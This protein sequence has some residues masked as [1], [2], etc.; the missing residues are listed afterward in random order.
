[1][2]GINIYNCH[3]E[4]KKDEHCLNGDGLYYY[5]INCHTNPLTN[6]LTNW[7]PLPLS[8][9]LQSELSSLYSS[10]H[11]DYKEVPDI[12]TGYYYILDRHREAQ[13]IHD[14]ISFYDRYSV[15]YTLLLYDNDKDILYYY[16]IDT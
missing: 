12:K 1:M 16:E 15:N 3:I 13:N 6:K 2:F 8:D 5:K 10:S 9:N 4:E 11:F 14:D 7:K